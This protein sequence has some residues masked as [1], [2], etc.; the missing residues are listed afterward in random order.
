MS[1]KGPE[2]G[3]AARRAF[4]GVCESIFE[5]IPKRGPLPVEREDRRLDLGRS[6]E[7]ALPQASI[8]VRGYKPTT[9]DVDLYSLPLHGVEHLLRLG[10][11]RLELVGGRGDDD[12]HR[13]ALDVLQD[14]ETVFAL[15]R[16][17]GH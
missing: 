10:Q 4:A 1:R 13:L 5:K 11:E 12:D 7:H 8:S 9:C 16:Y 15:L 17:V 14:D 2:A 3:A 6:L